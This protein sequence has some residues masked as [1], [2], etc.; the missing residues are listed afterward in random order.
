MH[1]ELS[2]LSTHDLKDVVNDLIA[3]PV[4]TSFTVKTDY[5]IPA[6]CVEF[7]IWSREHGFLVDNTDEEKAEQT[8]KAALEI[9]SRRVAERY[10]SEQAS[11]REVDTL[12]LS[13]GTDKGSI[14]DSMGYW[15]S[16]DLIID[17]TKRD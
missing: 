8:L 11:S 4:L 7:A 9:H 13:S 3:C 1:I 12:Y 5:E 10:R 17:V 15:T 6:E 16:Q 14:G 2:N